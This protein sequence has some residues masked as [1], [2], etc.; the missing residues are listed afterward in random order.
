[1]P[2]NKK[3]LKPFRKASPH[4]QV[5]LVDINR[6]L[7]DEKG[8]PRLLTDKDI[9]LILLDR[10]DTIAGLARQW[11]CSLWNL[12]AVIY[13][14]PH[15]VCQRERELLAG[16]IGCEVRQIGREPALKKAEAA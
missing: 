11:E 2:E 15:T 8:N 13:R 1:M 6:I 4:R 12:K 10:G 9:K 7:F 16:Y 14:L 3:Q 5:G